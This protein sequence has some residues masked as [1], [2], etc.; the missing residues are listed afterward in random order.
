MQDIQQHMHRVIDD[1]IYVED[2]NTLLKSFI[3]IR[4]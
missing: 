4:Q 1:Y 2:L 3:Y